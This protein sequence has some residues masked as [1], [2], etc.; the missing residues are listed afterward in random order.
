M[1]HRSGCTFGDGFYRIVMADG[2]RRFCQTEQ[3]VVFACSLLRDGAIRKVQRD[4]YCLDQDDLQSPH[5]IDGRLFLNMSKIQAMLE[6]GI[7]DEVQYQ[8]AYQAIAEAVAANDRNGGQ[9]SVVISKR[10]TVVH[11][12]A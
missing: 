10:G 7:D 1:S 11:D 2:S 5:V 12:A 4:G 6:L 8:R 3:E 9:A